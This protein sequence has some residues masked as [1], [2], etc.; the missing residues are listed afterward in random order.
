MADWLLVAGVGAES[1]DEAPM[2]TLATRLAIMKKTR[3]P[4]MMRW[5]FFFIATAN[6][7]SG[8]WRCWFV[9]NQRRSDEDVAARAD[10]GPEICSAM[11]CNEQPDEFCV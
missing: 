5:V 1:P 3:R 6:D 2:A 7:A 10:I 4:A 9:T 11:P 8:S